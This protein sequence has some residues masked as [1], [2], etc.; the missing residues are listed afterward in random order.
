MLHLSGLLSAVSLA[1]KICY[2]SRQPLR[3]RIACGLDPQILGC[4]AVPA[5]RQQTDWQKGGGHNG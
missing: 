2:A 5:R 1:S 4:S 3:R